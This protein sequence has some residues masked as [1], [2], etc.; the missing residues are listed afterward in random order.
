MFLIHSLTPTHTLSYCSHSYCSHSYCSHSYYSHFI[1]SQVY[2][3]STKF[4]CLIIVLVLTYIFSREYI[5]ITAVDFWIHTIEAD[6][7]FQKNKKSR[8]GLAGGAV[9][10][11]GA[12]GFGEDARANMASFTSS[13]HSFNSFSSSVS[14][15]SVRSPINL[16]KDQRAVEGAPDTPPQASLDTQSNATHNSHR[17]AQVPLSQSNIL[18]PST[19]LS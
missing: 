2:F 15:T 18:Y 12:A 4:W 14:S 5:V 1:A 9:A 3:G 16:Q 7:N 13:N 10:A 11:G 17:C 8:T 19:L 6:E